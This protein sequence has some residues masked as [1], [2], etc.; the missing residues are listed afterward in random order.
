MLGRIDDRAAVFQHGVAAPVVRKRY[1]KSPVIEGLQRF[2][3]QFSFSVIIICN[4]TP[5]KL[6]Y[7]I[8]FRKL[9]TAKR[10]LNHCTFSPQFSR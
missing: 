2:T 3:I 8:I 5:A 7:K 10:A 1:I 9:F 6:K 4:I